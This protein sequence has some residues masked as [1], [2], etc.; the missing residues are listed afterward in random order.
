MKAETR[1]ENLRVKG[2]S[3]RMSMT[4]TLN[5]AGLVVLPKAVLTMFGITG[6]QQIEID[7]QDDGVKLRLGHPAHTQESP[8]ARVEIRN[9]RSVIVPP[10]PVS[11]HD[12]V[13]AIK[14]DRDERTDTLARRHCVN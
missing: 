7:V 14:A 6:S 5:E 4:L 2:Q 13:K 1:V 12:I 10:L 8:L 3:H 11:S 9:G